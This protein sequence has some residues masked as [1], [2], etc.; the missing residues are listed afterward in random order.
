MS[1]IG[2]GEKFFPP[3]MEEKIRAVKEAFPKPSSE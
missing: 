1:V 2:H 3:E